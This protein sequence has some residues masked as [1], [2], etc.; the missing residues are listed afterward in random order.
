MEKPQVKECEAKTVIAI[1]HRGS[2]DEIGRVYHELNQW[3]R[4]HSVKVKGPGLTAFLDPP[5]KFDP[6]SGLFEVCLPVESP[7]AGDERVLVKEVPACTVAYVSVRGPYT[8]IP[9]HYTELLAW[10]SVEGREVAGPP[11]E[12]YITHPQ[13][14]DSAE[15]NEYLTE[16]QFPIN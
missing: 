1:R 15:Q 9:T 2:H 4:Q 8:Q 6:A 16:I 13:T 3:A 7:P 12:V 10:L 5:D 11:R 14:H